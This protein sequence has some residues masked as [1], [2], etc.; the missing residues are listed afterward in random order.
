MLNVA[1]CPNVNIS[2]IFVKRNSKLLKGMKNGDTAGQ[3]SGEM[4]T[5]ITGPTNKAVLYFH[6]GAYVM[7]SAKQHRSWT[8][9]FA[10]AAGT[11]V[12]AINYRLAP[13]YAFPLA[14]HDA[15]S[16]Y[17]Y[18][19]EQGYSPGNII[20]AG[21]SAGGGLAISLNLLLRDH[22]IPPPLCTVAMSP[23]LDLTH[24]LPSWRLNEYDYLPVNSRDPAFISK[25][26]SQYYTTNDG[27]NHHPYVS[28][29]FGTEAKG[30]IG[31]LLIQIGELERLRDENLM[32][33]SKSFTSSPIRLEM[34]KE[35]VHCF[36]GFEAEQ[37]SIESFKNIKKFISDPL[38]PINPG[39]YSL[40]SD[41]NYEC[42]TVIGKQGALEIVRNGKRML[43]DR[44]SQ[45]EL[46]SP[47]KKPSL[48]DSY[49][50][51]TNVHNTPKRSIIP[52]HWFIV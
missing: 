22:A 13:D 31:P 18:L 28:P 4:L 47:G 2:P 8:I 12:F 11:R 15:L 52:Q 1:H 9:K 42:E 16:A 40:C 50:S 39:I 38:S 33:A 32:F 19:L 25:T 30:K 44:A 48:L 26:R 24:S 5:P 6:G 51:H 23:W 35:Q 43:E 17:L 10:K 14:L 7:S 20:V 36:H 34:Y 29:L 3:I 45:H 46:L 21:D 37:A 27:L 49:F 41:S